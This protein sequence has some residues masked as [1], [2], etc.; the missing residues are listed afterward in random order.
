MHGGDRDPPADNHVLKQR[1]QEKAQNIN[2]GEEVNV[3]QATPQQEWARKENAGSRRKR[4]RRR[5]W[6]DGARP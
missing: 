3:N 4:R 2:Q 1:G 6:N 5:L